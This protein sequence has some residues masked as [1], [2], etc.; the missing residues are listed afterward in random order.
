MVAFNF[1]HRIAD[2]ARPA[3]LPTSSFDTTLHDALRL[4][5]VEA[6][7]L[8]TMPR[9]EVRS[10]GSAA[11]LRELWH[12]FEHGN[13]CRP[14]LVVLVLDEILS[15]NLR[16][17]VRRRLSAGRLILV[18]CRGHWPGMDSAGDLALAASRLGWQSIEVR[19]DAGNA[20]LSAATELGAEERLLV[21]VPAHPQTR[22]IM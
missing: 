18:P 17:V 12:R 15:G 7:S 8:E 20:L 1:I 16:E 6:C 13:A 5:E 9:V 2:M 19:R 14:V 4:C 10:Y 21:L 3:L 22:R 11:E